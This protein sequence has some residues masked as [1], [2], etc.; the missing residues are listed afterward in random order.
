MAD[1]IEERKDNIAKRI[2]KERQKK[3]KSQE[4]FP[5]ISRTYLDVTQL[6]KLLFRIGKKENLF[7]L[8]ID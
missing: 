4:A 3:Y 1:I 7:P 5:M 2:K 6:N 8:L